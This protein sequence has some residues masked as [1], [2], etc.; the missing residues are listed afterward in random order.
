MAKGTKRGEGRSETKPAAA[1]RGKTKAQEELDR[2]RARSAAAA[3]PGGAPPSP[4]STAI[5][6]VMPAGPGGAPGWALPPSVM[7][8]PGMPGMP[9]MPGMPAMPAMPAGTGGIGDRVGS[10]LGLGVDVVNQLLAGSVRLLQ[11]LAGG[12]Y[13]YAPQAYGGHGGGHGHGC[14]CGCDCG[15][16]CGCGGGCDPCLSDCCGY[17]CCGVMGAGGC[18]RPSVGNCC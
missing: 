14:G 15:G 6:W 16:G 3:A 11:G 2:F 1:P 9:S 12:A 18:C 10:T 13:G 5:P 4:F 17:D 7:P 8:Y